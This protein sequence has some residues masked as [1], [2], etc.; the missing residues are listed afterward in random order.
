MMG[1]L[2]LGPTFSALAVLAIDMACIATLTASVTTYAMYSLVFVYFLA[3][4]F[5]VLLFFMFCF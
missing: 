4:Y 5:F 3:I 2:I 1:P